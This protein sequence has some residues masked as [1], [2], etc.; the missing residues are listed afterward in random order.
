VK[1]VEIGHVERIENTPMFGREGQLLLVRLSVR[2]ASRAVITVNTTRTKRSDKIAVHRVFVDVDP[3]REDH[4][5][6]CCSRTS[7]SCASASRSASIS[8]WLA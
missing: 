3:D 8:A 4:R 2:P 5:R 7:V 1:S 6:C